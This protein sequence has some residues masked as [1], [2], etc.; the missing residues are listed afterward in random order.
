MP[1][2]RPKLEPFTKLILFLDSPPLGHSLCGGSNRSCLCFLQS[3]WL[4]LWLTAARFRGFF[5]TTLF[6]T[7]AVVTGNIDQP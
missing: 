3:L 6:W 7:F 1:E 4:C 2:S 5:A